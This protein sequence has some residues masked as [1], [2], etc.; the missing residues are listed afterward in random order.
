[1]PTIS[2]FPKSEEA[3]ILLHAQGLCKAFGGQ[4]VLDKIE[5]ELRQGEVILLRGENGSGKTTLLNILTGNLKPDSGEIN[6]FSNGSP[7]SYC[8]PQRWWQELNPFDHFT[9]EFV[10]REGIG[11]TWQDVR[12]FGSQS[13]RDNLA[14]AMS[15]RFGDNPFFALFSPHHVI[16]REVEINQAANTMLTHLGLAGRED[17]SADKISLGQSKRVAIARAVLSG[18]KILFLDEPLSGLDRQ[19]IND[20][21]TLL[22]SLVN[23]QHLTL[24]I[25]EHLFNQSHLQGLITTDWLLDNRDITVSTAQTPIHVSS[26]DTARPAWFSLLAGKNTDF[27]EESL[28]HGALLTR[29]RQPDFFNSPSNPVLEIKD[30]VINRGQRDIIG[31]DDQGDIRGFSLTLYEGEI[32]ILQAP[33]GWGKSTLIGAISGLITPRL[34]DICL[35]GQSINDNPVW[36]RIHKGLKVLT[37]NE[38]LFPNLSVKEIIEITNNQTDISIFFPNIANRK[39]SSLSGG[40]KQRL[41]FLCQIAPSL[42]STLNVLDEPFHGLDYNAVAE[43]ITH[44]L[45]G[46]KTKAV[47]ITIP[48]GYKP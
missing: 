27:I 15:N 3:P 39:C 18:A 32:V 16:E 43:V 30:L 8:F 42:S 38:K 20:V 25:V 29:I 45:S 41:A 4:V 7:R 14:I 37:S 1:M 11:R 34:G 21:L 28:P 48:F 17:S 44:L 23:E 47:F 26:T 24:V 35:F 6:Y 19:G 31:L 9:P 40:E 22:Q 10:A 5:L 2:V 13:L 12:L 46:L 33:N 36:E